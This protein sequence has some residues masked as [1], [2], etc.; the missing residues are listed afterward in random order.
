VI[1]MRYFRHTSGRVRVSITGRAFELAHGYTEVRVVP[2]DAIVIDPA[3]VATVVDATDPTNLGPLNSA[4]IDYWPTNSLVA[5]DA[6][7]AVDAARG[8]VVSAASDFIDVL[9]QRP[10][11]DGRAH[12]VSPTKSLEALALTVRALREVTPS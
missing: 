4:P 10:E 8:A 12:H 11:E 6:A 9:N 5:L 2:L 1:L 7:E 3:I